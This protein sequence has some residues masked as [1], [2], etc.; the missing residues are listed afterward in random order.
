MNVI[1]LTFSKVKSTNVASMVI[2]TF[3]LFCNWLKLHTICL[4]VVP[5]SPQ[6]YEKFYKTAY[7][8]CLFET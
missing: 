4:H 3:S 8:K 2:A 5:S 1:A 6:A 7:I